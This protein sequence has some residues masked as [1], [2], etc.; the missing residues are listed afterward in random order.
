RSRVGYRHHEVGGDGMLAR[1]LLTQPLAGGIHQLTIEQAVGTGEVDVLERARRARGRRRARE[2]LGVHTVGADRQQ[3][4]RRYLA[5][6][7]RPDG[8]ERTAL[9]RDRPAVGEPAAGE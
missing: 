3:L 8:V 9:G 6:E 4:A 2:L 5:N 1:K 7:L